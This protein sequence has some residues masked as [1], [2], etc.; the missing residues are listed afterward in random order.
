[1]L[2]EEEGLGRSALHA[3]GHL[4]T[5]VVCLL[6]FDNI[7]ELYRF[8]CVGIRVHPRPQAVGSLGQCQER[9]IIMDIFWLRHCRGARQEVGQVVRCTW[10]INHIEYVF[11]KANSS[12]HQASAWVRRAVDTAKCLVIRLDEE[13]SPIEEVP[14]LEDSP[15]DAE[16]FA[17]RGGVV[18]LC[19]SQSSASISDRMK[20]FAR[21]LLE[22]CTANLVGACVNVDD[23]FT[24][25]LR[26]GKYRK[27]QQCVAEVLE[28]GAGHVRRW[29]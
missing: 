3:S 4:D 23:D 17:L 1:M 10:F 7:V 13:P 18:L 15:Q 9:Y 28:G 5:I 27:A 14:Q 11:G 26:Q 25:G 20:Q 8:R 2:V 12:S 21:F 29:W 16:E 19:S 24:I 6:C 22:E